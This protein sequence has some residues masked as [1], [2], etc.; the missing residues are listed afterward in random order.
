MP[1]SPP[2]DVARLRKSF[3]DDSVLA[4][5]YTMYVLDT[6]HLLD[7]LRAAIDAGDIQRV[8]RTG[9]TLKGSSANIGAAGMCEVAT[10]L[11]KTDIGDAGGAV[12]SLAGALQRE[13]AR[14][15]RFVNDFIAHAE[16]RA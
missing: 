7:E 3:D 12:A 4:E 11:E 5:L 15:E 10:V 9:H 6:S 8:C 1:E 13:F 14:V 16:S 2:I